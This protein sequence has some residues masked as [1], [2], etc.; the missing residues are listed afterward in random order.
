MSVASGATCDKDEEDE[1]DDG[2]DKDKEDDCNEDPRRSSE[3]VLSAAR[4]SSTQMLEATV[5]RQ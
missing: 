1:E 3:P 5:M 4:A 2:K